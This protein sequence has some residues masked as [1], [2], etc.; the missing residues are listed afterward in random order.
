MK[1]EAKQKPA[2]TKQKEKTG[3]DRK[4]YVKMSNENQNSTLDDNKTISH[5]REIAN[6]TEQWLK[7][8][9]VVYT[10]NFEKPLLKRRYTPI[11][12][13]TLVEL[14]KICDY[15]EQTHPN[16]PKPI[17]RKCKVVNDCLSEIDKLVVEGNFETAHSKLDSLAHYIWRLIETLRSSADILQKQVN[18]DS[19]QN[20]PTTAEYLSGLLKLLEELQ[21]ALESKNQN[22]KPECYQ[23][24]EKYISPKE[25]FVDV[26]RQ[27]QSE[28]G[29]HNEHTHNAIEIV[30]SAIRDGSFPYPALWMGLADAR[31]IN[32]LKRWIKEASTK[33]SSKVVDGKE[34]RIK[35]KDFIKKYCD[36]SD[37]PDI[38]SKCEMLL[39]ERR[40]KRI[41]LP[42][43]DINYRP[44]QR[45]LYRLDD[46]LSNW[47][48]Y[49]MTLTTLPP[50][51]ESANK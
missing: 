3:E 5:L 1:V 15:L 22:L 51:K 6:R 35:L 38:D 41:E 25:Q 9:Y 32:E 20:K 40:N 45:Y 42:L 14:D 27:C 13:P 28:Y 50:L 4:E 44:G 48:N 11:F 21:S 33:R 49:R 7:S 46:L 30:A 16:I 23:R 2:E 10:R 19:R 34:K 17:Q 18:I 39:R 24:I 37:K 47:S 12:G 8:N 26:L 43:V 31:F 36:L 29:C